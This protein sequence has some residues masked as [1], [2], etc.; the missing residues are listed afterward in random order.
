MGKISAIRFMFAEAW[1]NARIYLLA[2]IIKNIFMA[3]TPLLNIAGIG[4]VV[5]ALISDKKID[6]ILTIIIVY[7]GANL[8]ILLAGQA[9][10]LWANY[11]MRK[12]SNLL[13]YQYMQ[14]CLD[15]DYDFVQD[16]KIANLK[17]RSMIAEPA[18]FLSN[19]GVFIN[20][21]IQFTG[22]ISIFSILSPWFIVII[23]IL[24]TILIFLTMYKQKCDFVFSNEKVVDDR[25]LDYLYNVMT[26]YKY[27][28]EIRINN[29]KPF[30]RNKYSMIL[31]N[32]IGKLKK[33]LRKKLKI[34]LLS[35]FLTII[36]S[37]IMYVYFTNKVFIN[38]INIA[39]YTVLLSS[40]TLFTSLLL[41]LFSNIGTI[42]NSIKAMVFL[43]E[44]RQTLK[45]NRHAWNSNFQN[46]VNID[47]SNAEIKF[48][49]VSFVYPNTTHYALKNINISII[50]GK[51]LGIVGLNGAGKTTLIKL[52]LRIYIPTSGR[53]TLDGVDISKI[54][55][56]QYVEHIG[57]V[58]Q[59]FSLF[60]YS[61]K[62]NI[63]F[64]KRV[65][66]KKLYDSL[67][68]SGLINKISN[69]PKGI[70]TSVYRELDD[71]GIEFSGGE[72]QKLA[73]AKAI[74]KNSDVLIL[75]EPTSSLDPISEYSLFSKLSKISD[76]KTTVFIS[77]R[78]SSTRLCDHI[79]VIQEGEII[80][81]GSHSELLLK[82]G[83]YCTLF[84]S[85]ARY[86]NETEANLF[87]N[88]R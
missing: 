12:S 1:K 52:L 36:Q 86:Y 9:L 7:V 74:Y 21:F 19:W 10:S 42:N 32:Q 79:I 81:Q 68:K 35:S 25:K 58:L 61:I 63:V 70:D 34:D 3:L 13:Q 75:D 29:A 45:E 60:A 47:F 77:H 6:D 49:N 20:Y 57:V 65:D 82:E 53:I 17:R 56:R 28:K 55:Y 88:L 59:D 33:L 11:A 54:P 18:F 2:T 14:E 71:N 64:D 76:N 27:A 78:L 15:I 31:K 4:L 67:E 50:P 66:E 51:K 80:E 22:V 5:D 38:D 26:T 84:E 40:T 87:E 30:I 37:A 8:I 48:E 16:G 39:E 41:S 85:Q 69:L 62:E 72:G 44:Y 23:L 83:V 24:S 73:M 43:N 46:D